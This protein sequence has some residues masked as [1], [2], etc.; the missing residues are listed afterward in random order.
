MNPGD[1]EKHRLPRAVELEKRRYIGFT[2]TPVV[3]DKK[4]FPSGVHPSS[5]DPL[6]KHWPRRRAWFE[7]QQ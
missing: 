4:V 1:H 5:S 3:E 6:Q 2:A 7:S